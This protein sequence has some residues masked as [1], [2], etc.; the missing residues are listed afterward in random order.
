MTA[1]A[2]LNCLLLAPLLILA[3]ALAAHGGSFPASIKYKQTMVR[4]IQETDVQGWPT[5][6][7]TDKRYPCDI[8]VSANGAKV[9]F[10]VKLNYF[11]DKHIFVMNADGTGL[12]DLTP[13]LPAGMSTRTGDIA[14]LQ[15]NDTGSRLFFMDYPNGNIY[16]FDTS[17][18]YTP[19][20]AY[21][22]NAF[23]VPPLKA[24]AL[25]SDGSRIYLQ[26]FWLVGTPPLT[27]THN[28]LCYTDVGSNTLAPVVDVLSL[29]PAPT[30]WGLNFLDAAR[31]G[32]NLLFMYYPDYYHDNLQAMWQFLPLGAMP[33]ERHGWV[34]SLP[35][36]YT[37]LMSADGSK[38][39]YNYQDSGG[40]P[41]LYLVNMVSGAK[42]LL[43]SNTGEVGFPALSPDG[44]WARFF[45]AGCNATRVN[46]ATL[47]KRDTLSARFPESGLVGAGNLTDFT[48]DNRYYFMSS[49]PNPACLHRIDMAPTSTAPA[50]DITSI[51][52][53]R[54]N[55][56]LTDTNP[57]TVT[58]QV[59]DPKGL[60]NIQSVQMHSLV[61]GQE[62]PS[63]LNSEPLYYTADLVNAGGGLYTT[64][65]IAYKSS[66]FYTTH[67]LPWPVGVRIVVRNKD[68]HYVMADAVINVTTKGALSGTGAR[69]LLL[70]D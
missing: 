69:S 40:N 18:P 53:S 44:A 3:G 19:H 45:A 63:G 34:W 21:L 68:E 59:S 65:F 49:D 67:R 64:T 11:S 62:S 1:I 27:E 22:P 47:D 58:V 30:Y 51:S 5:G 60:S 20:P 26:H 61:D 15:I 8:M 41:Q 42:T 14:A 9:G 29:T 37:H 12:V 13:N 4:L 17:P 10:L 32:G 7:T 56:I 35:W 24:Y 38:A 25:N 6:Y 39:L 16:Y 43:N 52:F 31:T 55:L 46:L 36:L 70:L 54:P 2:K 23:W 48:A 28:G 57:V 33:N 66:N 50:P